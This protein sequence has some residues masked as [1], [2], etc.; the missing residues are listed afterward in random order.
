MENVHA[1]PT[2]NTL[3]MPA[4]NVGSDEVEETKDMAVE[5]DVP[6][7]ISKP[8]DLRNSTTQVVLEDNA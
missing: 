5:G 8:P 1:Y 6:D 2:T 7:S 4:L 3:D